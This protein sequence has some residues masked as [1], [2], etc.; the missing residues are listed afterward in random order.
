M[1]FHPTS[2]TQILQNSTKPKPRKA[3]SKP[4]NAKE[5]AWLFFFGLSLFNELR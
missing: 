1:Y 2:K 3:K 4:R 5:K